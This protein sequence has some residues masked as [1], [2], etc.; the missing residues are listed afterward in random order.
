MAYSTCAMENHDLY[1]SKFSQAL[2]KIAAPLSIDIP[3]IHSQH[4]SSGRHTVIV[5]S[6]LLLLASLHFIGCFFFVN[7]SYLDLD[8]YRA[9]KVNMPYRARVGMEPVLNLAARSSIVEKIAKRLDTNLRVAHPRSRFEPIT[10]AELGAMA[11]S[12]ISVITMTG[13]AIYYGY[14]RFRPIW[15]LPAS[16]MLAMLFLTQASRYE[17]AIWLPYDLPNDLLF[18]TSCLFILEGG[19]LPAFLLF[20]LDLPIR[21]TS[22]FLAVVLFCSAWS[23]GQKKQAAWWA[24]SMFI[25]WAASRLYVAH[26]YAGVPSEQGISIVRILRTLASPVHWP[27]IASAFGFLL[28]PMCLAHWRLS[29]PQRAFLYGAVPCLVLILL[30]GVWQE[31]RI[32]NEWIFPSA[33]LVTAEVLHYLRSLELSPVTTT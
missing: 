10:P 21:E 13:I 6:A 24:G 27:Q 15:W 31:T 5:G 19:W 30:F 17:T 4:R 9:G 11:A 14:L 23:K 26:R 3:V 25:L 1:K 32:F 29:I 28:I 20:L 16:L 33:V 2:V 8:A 18:G 22:I 7:Y 12:L